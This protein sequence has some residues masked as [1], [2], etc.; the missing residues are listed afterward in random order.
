MKNELQQLLDEN[1]KVYI[2][3]MNDSKYIEEC[4]IDIVNDGYHNVIVVPMVLT[5]GHTLEIL[6]ARIEKMKLFNLNINIKYVEPL[7]NNNTISVSYVKTIEKYINRNKL[8]DIGVVL[9]GEGEK[10][11]NR[12]SHIKSAKENLMLRNKIKSY[13]I[14]DLGMEEYKI[15]T[16][17]F[18]FIEPNYSDTVNN[19][20]EYSVGNILIVY[21]NP[22]ASN[23]DNSII[24]RKIK[25][26]VEFPEGVKARVLDGF[27]KDS[28]IT[29]EIKN[30]VEFVNL[31]KCE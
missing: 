3:Y 29:N 14:S 20:L 6:K 1:Y 17:W 13:L 21:V 15:K 8:T 2:S 10:G 9:V 12:G 25:S 31:Q 5:D 18:N 22:S 30:M 27:L 19:L 23:I 28:S 16:A 24:A 11:Y 4:L 26:S 7:W